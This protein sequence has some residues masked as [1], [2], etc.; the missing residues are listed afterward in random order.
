G[1]Y[2]TTWAVLDGALPALLAADGGAARGAGELLAVA[3]DCVER[4]G[5]SGPG[6]EGLTAI[7]SRT[8]SSQL[9][10][11]ARRLRAALAAAEPEAVALA[12]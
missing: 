6:P 9:V 11:Q 2:A 5:A 8:G 7:A 4:S 3:A 10:T 12:S 1:A